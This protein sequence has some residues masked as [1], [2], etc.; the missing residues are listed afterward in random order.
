M[1][2]TSTEAHLCEWHPLLPEPTQRPT[3]GL[4]N[5]MTFPFCKQT[6]KEIINH[7][8]ALTNAAKKGHNETREIHVLL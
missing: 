1:F 4:G 6:F 7:S 8:Q 5:T 3:D 2:W